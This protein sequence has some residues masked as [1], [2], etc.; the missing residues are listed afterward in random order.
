MLGGLRGRGR[1]IGG[2][3]VKM[4]GE[5]LTVGGIRGEGEGLRFGVVRVS[6]I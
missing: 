1:G 2:I 3:L 4:I 6:K 5:I